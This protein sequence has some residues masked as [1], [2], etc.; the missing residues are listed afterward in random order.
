M[1]AGC[2]GSRGYERYDVGPRFGVVRSFALFSE[3]TGETD[4]CGLPVPYNWAAE[5]QLCLD[6][7]LMPWSAILDKKASATVRAAW[8][9]G[10]RFFD[11]APFYGAALAEIRLG[12]K[13]AKVEKIKSLCN[14]FE[15]P[16]KSAALQF[17]L[18]H[19][20][21]AAVIPGATRPE[22]IAED[23]AA[24]KTVVPDEF[25]K[26]LRKQKLVSPIAPLPIDHK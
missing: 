7:E 2:R 22:R 21:S 24:M 9:A 17:S 10:T 26:E 20:S 16:I 19:P 6:C 8:D 14:K 23:H 11:T 25:W 1:M 18:A 15:I 12:K 13:L 4:N 3:T 5:Y